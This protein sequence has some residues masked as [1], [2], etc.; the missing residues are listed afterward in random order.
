ME[1]SDHIRLQRLSQICFRMGVVSLFLL[2]LVFPLGRFFVFTALAL[3]TLFFGLWLYYRRLTRD[4]EENLY[5][6]LRNIPNVRPSR[7]AVSPRFRTAVLAVLFTL[8]SFALVIVAIV[9]GNN[10]RSTPAEE[11]LGTGTWHSNNSAYDSAIF[12][13]DKVLEVEPG[14]TPA[15]Y[16]KGLSLYN[17][18]KYQEATLP[19]EEA[20]KTDPGYSQ[21]MLLLGDCHYNAVNYPPALEWYTKAYELGERSANLSHLL[22]FLHD[23][24][25]ESDPAI[26]FYKETLSMDSS[27]VDIYER[28]AVLEPAN[29][30]EYTRL[31]GRWKS[32]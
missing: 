29:A 15:L 6:E 21:A 28:L 27:R 31:A 26:A 25:G 3:I 30:T 12:Y 20:I 11:W 10:S 8:F 14:N 9:W 7:P 2:A 13:F 22:A 24:K 32:Q 1:E 23:N 17:L 19:L 4:P 18:G 5:N 16:N